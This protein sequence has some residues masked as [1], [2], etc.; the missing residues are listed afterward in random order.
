MRPWLL[1]L[2]TS[3][4][5]GALAG[6]GIF[7]TKSS[8]VPAV[9]TQSS[10]GV[11]P[12]VQMVVALVVVLAMV[13]WVMPGLIKRYG[14]RFNH[15]SG[16]GIRVE[17]TATLGATNLAVVVVR[18]KTLLI[19]TTAENVSC[20]ADLTSTAPAPPTFQEILETAPPDT[21]QYGFTDLATQL[22][23]LRRIGA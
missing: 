12:L 9:D 19:G 20:L 22:E 10:V 21:D 15:S 5:T 14:K 6:T 11:F 3:L 7:G 18:G 13:R 23:R 16:S 8:P 4:T 1:I 2:G 17:D